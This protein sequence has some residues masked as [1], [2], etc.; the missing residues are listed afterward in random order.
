MSI[1]LSNYKSL[2]IDDCNLTRLYVNELLVWKNYT[3]QVPLSINS[4]G[5]T[6]NTTGY[7]NGY[8]VRSG[9]AETT[10]SVSF[11]TGFI[12]VKGGDII[13]I[14]GCEFSQSSGGNA[15]NVSDSSFT[16]IGQFTSQPASYGIFLQDSYKSYNYSSV[17]EE[18]AGVYKWTVPPTAS[19]TAYIRLTGISNLSDK[20]SQCIVTINEPISKLAIPS[21][22]NL[23]PTA[24]DTD[25]SIYNSIGYLTNSRLNSSGGVSAGQIGSITTGFIPITSNHIIQM[26]G[27]T[28][29][30]YTTGNYHYLSFYD[31]SFAVLGSVSYNITTNYYRGI[32]KNTTSITTKYNITTFKPVFTDGS[33]IAYFRINGASFTPS[34]M[35]VT[36]SLL[37]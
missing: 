25:G 12:P 18:S 28:W 14:Y 33:A 13:R 23:V 1:D 6:Y 10:N 34:N 5:T 31:S 17:I 35:V 24:I 27:A 2:S 20:G 32:V 36:T 11:C 22:T 16:N 29:A 3:N 19:G 26:G 7:K 30:P 9:G 37:S 15:I 8:R 21:G 4:D